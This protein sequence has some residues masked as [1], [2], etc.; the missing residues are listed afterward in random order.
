MRGLWRKPWLWYAV[1]VATFLVNLLVAFV[2]IQSH[3]SSSPVVHD[4]MAGM[5]L[6]PS[7]QK[8]QGPPAVPALESQLWHRMLQENPDCADPLQPLHLRHGRG[9][10][11]SDGAGGEDLPPFGFSADLRAYMKENPNSSLCVPPPTGPSCEASRYAVIIY[12]T[13][14]RLRQLLVHTMAFVAYP[15]V[16][17]IHL[18]LEIDEETL[19]RDAKYGVRILSWQ[20]QGVIKIVAG[21]SPWDAIDRLADDDFGSQAV[22]WINGDNPK[23][24]NGTT[25]KSRLNAWRDHPD[26]LSI[27]GFVRSPDREICPYP[28]LHGTYMHRDYFCYL[29]HP[30]ASRP[31]FHATPFGWDAGTEAIAVYLYSIGHGYTMDSNDVNVTIPPRVGNHGATETVLNYFGCQC[32]AKSSF[33]IVH[34]C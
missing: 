16:S 9:S 32:F 14:R 27:A 28:L 21:Q 4:G 24:W 34:Q 6:D 26:A 22:L 2:T 30:V 11:P 15:S 29:K 20:E 3:V 12:G 33:P 10:T 19:S 13:G 1:V 31:R 23:I 8:R 5:L 7:W 18:L 25:F 17:D